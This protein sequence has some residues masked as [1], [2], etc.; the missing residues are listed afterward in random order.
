MA[1]YQSVGWWSWRA[2]LSALSPP[3]THH[4]CRMLDL[5][6]HHPVPTGLNCPLFHD[7][8]ESLLRC[9]CAAL[10]VRLAR[11]VTPQDLLALVSSFVLSRPFYFEQVFA[12]FTQL[13]VMPPGMWP[14]GHGSV[15]PLCPAH[16][17]TAPNSV[18]PTDRSPLRF[19]L[20]VQPRSKLHS[21]FLTRTQ[22]SG[23]AGTVLSCEC[24]WKTTPLSAPCPRLSTTGSG[25][26]L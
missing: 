16:I 12:E 21:S 23:R 26:L 10:S 7:G 3:L 2:I 19:P 15:L 13:L 9:V 5:V 14:P 25:A 6:Q 11:T 20:Q 17:H 4:A 24:F 8:P 22:S 18:N 1:G